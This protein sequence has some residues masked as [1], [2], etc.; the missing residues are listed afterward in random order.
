MNKILSLRKNII[1][2]LSN[3]ITSDYVLLDIPDHNNI[4]DNLIWEGEIDYL[5]TLP[6]KNKGEY[7]YWCLEEKQQFLV[8]LLLFHGGG[9][10]GDI[11]PEVNKKR[12]SII[13][14][15]FDKRIVVFPQSV[16]YN[17]H[18]VLKDDLNVLSTHPDLHICV[19]D[20]E[21]YNLLKDGGVEKVYL[22]PDMAFCIDFEKYSVKN[23]STERTLYMRRKDKEIDSSKDEKV[24]SLLSN[25]EVKDWPTFNIS[26]NQHRIDYRK[27]RYNKIVSKKLLQLP[28]LNKLVDTRYGLKSRYQRE[29]YIKQGI[30]FFEDY[31]H[32]VT[33]RL[34]G[35]ILAVLM[36]KQVSIVDNNNKKLTRFYNMWLKDF[37]N[38]KVLMP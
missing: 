13:L 37:T 24:L 11:Y 38:V 28:F 21:S 36:N 7:A 1:S 20:E 31:D 17:D 25:A 9:N 34:H 18:Q 30:A 8:P 22:I 16:Y 12:I 19:R 5:S 14:N 15:N 2:V 6:F 10:F 26:K 35:L 3:L 23:S 27:E 4:G 29:K 33:T 32:I